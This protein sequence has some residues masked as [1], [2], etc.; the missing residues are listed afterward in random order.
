[1]PIL[2]CSSILA[3]GFYQ[4][5]SHLIPLKFLIMHFLSPFITS[6]EGFIPDKSKS[7]GEKFFLFLPLISFSKRLKASLEEEI[8]SA[9]QGNFEE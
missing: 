2:P 6:V 5:H 3:V 7:K 4:L 1:M 9:K 8:L